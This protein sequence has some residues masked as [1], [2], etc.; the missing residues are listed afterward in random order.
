MPKAPAIDFFRKAN[1][2]NTRK[3]VKAAKT[4]GLKKGIILTS[5]F[6]YFARKYPEWKLTE[7]HPYIKSRIEQEDVALAEVEENFSIVILQLPYVIGAMKGKPPLLKPLIKYL[8]SP[9]P[10]FFMKG[11]TAVIS[12][13]QIGEAIVKSLEDT[14][15]SNIYPIAT[16][17]YTWDQ[18]IQQINPKKKKII[19][20]PKVFLHVF[21]FFVNIFHKL[22]GK[23]GGLNIE[24]YIE[25]QT[26]EQ[27]L[28]LGQNEKFFDIC[29]DDLN[30]A[31]E[32]MVYESLN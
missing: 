30:N 22:Q 4:A 3:V 5:Y 28:D 2:E 19:H 26:S 21:G 12:V 15:L 18:F 32:E 20:I 7:Y 6:G 17:N 24:K 14:I 23:E 29:K 1:V 8:H 11:G 10:T 13:R 31:F 25:M 27:F 9:L 16:R